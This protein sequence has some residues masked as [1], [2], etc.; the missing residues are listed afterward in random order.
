MLLYNFQNAQRVFLGNL[1]ISKI[2]LGSSEI[3]SSILADPYSDYVSL[4]LHMEGLQGSKTFIDSSSN[5]FPVLTAVNFPPEAAAFSNTTLNTSIKKF[6]NSSAFFDGDGD[7]ILVAVNDQFKFNGDF[8]IEM[9]LYPLSFNTRMTLFDNLTFI[10]GTGITLWLIENTGLYRVA[11]VSSDIGTSTSGPVLNQWN[12]VALVR[13]NGVIK[14]FNNCVEVLSVVNTTNFNSGGCI[15]GV[16]LPPNLNDPLY[17]FNG[18]IDDYRVTNGIARYT[19]NFTPPTEQLPAPSDPYSENVSLLLH[20]DGLS[21]SQVFADSSTNN[22]TLTAF[23]GAQID[24]SIKK[25]GSA[26]ASF[27]GIDSYIDVDGLPAD[28]LSND[29]TIEFW[30]WVN[31]GNSGFRTVFSAFPHYSLSINLNGS[32]QETQISIGN[33]TVWQGAPAIISQDSLSLEV[34]NHLA[35]V[36]Y[37][38][39]ITLYHNGV[40]Q[41]TTNILPTGFTQKL[42]FGAYDNTVGDGE[43]FN[44]YIDELRITKGFARY[45]SNFIP[46][47]AP[48]PNP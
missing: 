16:T 7:H 11:T 21:G 45:T 47:T 36:S 34:W 13:N 4:L 26:A 19:S 5:N 31:A 37:N 32:V 17:S 43:F 20:M 38:G 35:L 14:I 8:T 41:G 22:F 18:Y 10:I 46:Q 27:N 48:F 6:G 3:F 39:T 2:F 1:D 42:R 24:T 12:H 25:F 40:S 23:G 28:Y 30:V 9:W 44:G 33:G 15:I 29:F